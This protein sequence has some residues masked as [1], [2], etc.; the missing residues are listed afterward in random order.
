MISPVQLP[1]I[2]D[3]KT[4]A[5]AKR[6]FLINTS[7]AQIQNSILY[8]FQGK[9]AEF[10]RMT[11]FRKKS[12]ECYGP[13]LSSSSKSCP[14]SF[15]KVL[16]PQ[17]QTHCQP[18][19]SQRESAGMATLTLRITLLHLCLFTKHCPHSPP[20]ATSK[21]TLLDNKSLVWLC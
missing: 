16:Q 21:E 7:R 19:F 14:P 11:E 17:F 2:R 13:S 15:L 1:K 12:S 3:E 6:R 4:W 10:R 9:H 20:R 18:C 8:I 5:I